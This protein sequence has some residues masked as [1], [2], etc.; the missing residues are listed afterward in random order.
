MTIQNI[1]LDTNILIDHMKGVPEAV[2]LVSGTDEALISIIS[3]IELLVDVRDPEEEAKTKRFLATF[4]TINLD[5]NVV[6][7]SARLKRHLLQTGAKKMHMPDLIIRAT[8][9]I[10]SAIINTLNKADFPASASVVHPYPPVVNKSPSI[11]QQAAA[12]Q[13]ATTGNASVTPI[14]AAQPGAGTKGSSTP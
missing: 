9:T 2:T 10:H 13:A 7:E 6:L 12:A 14:T 3:H 5:D 4:K 11:R 1:L 8:A